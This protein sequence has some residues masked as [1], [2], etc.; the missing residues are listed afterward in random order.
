MVVYNL[1]DD[2]NSADEQSMPVIIRNYQAARN[3]AKNKSFIHQN[4]IDI[5]VAGK[6]TIIDVYNMT[7]LEAGELMVLSKGTALISQALPVDGLFH[8][9][10]MYFTNEVFA[11][12]W[13]KY[14]AL[15]KE[16]RNDVPKCAFITYRQDDF[17]GHYIQSLL[18]LL[19]TPAIFS[20]QLKQVKLE[21]LLLYLLHTDPAKLHSLAVNVANSDDMQI[22]KVVESHITSPITTEELAFLCHTSLSTFKRKFLLLYG[23]SP[24]KWLVRKRMQVAADLLKLPHERSGSVYEKV[25]YE[26]QSGF[27]VAFKSQYGVTPT[28]YQRRNLNL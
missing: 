12:F 20:V 24:Q 15:R 5:I 27:I 16:S 11:D 8:N 25:G 28:E 1:P 23:T 18:L 13:I 22:R 17:I 26:N 4:M 19:K 9:L 10:V 2:F 3:S 6:K 7:A 14:I 21:E